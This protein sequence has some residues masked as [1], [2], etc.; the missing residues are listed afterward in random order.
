M[1]LL[2]CQG[3]DLVGQQEPHT[4]EALGELCELT[5]GGLAGGASPNASPQFSQDLERLVGLVDGRAV[6]QG[7]GPLLSF[8]RTPFRDSLLHPRSWEGERVLGLPFPKAWLSHLQKYL[9]LAQSDP[10]FGMEPE[11]RPGLG[12]GPSSSFRPHWLGTPELRDPPLP[13]APWRA[14]APSAVGPR[15]RGPPGQG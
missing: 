5:F 9:L 1:R 4:E 8:Q 14:P 3:R 10:S 13:R 6:P 7:H 12:P 11:M 15:P 2:L